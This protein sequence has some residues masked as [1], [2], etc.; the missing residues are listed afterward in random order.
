[1]K[2]WWVAPSARG[3]RSCIARTAEATPRDPFVA[4]FPVRDALAVPLRAES[5]VVGVL[6]AGRRGR[7]VPFTVEDTILLLVIADRVA[8][9]LSHQRLVDRA[10]DHLARLRELQVFSGQAVVGRDLAD[11]LA[12]ACEVASRLLGV[13]AAALG[14]LEGASRLRL[15]AS[16]GLSQD[17]IERWSADVHAGLAREVYGSG[18]PLAVRDLRDRAGEAE[19][20][21]TALGLRAGLLVPLRIHERTVGAALPRR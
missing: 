4:R 17:G 14:L 19:E 3:G 20:F 21:L 10:A 7:G 15:A 9:A 16:S 2:A 5:Q 13:R 8:T 6:F 11:T 1:M 12:R 18:L